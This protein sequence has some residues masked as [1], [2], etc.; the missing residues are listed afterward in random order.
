MSFEDKV[1]I[2]TGAGQGIGEGYARQLA[3]EGASV[4]V[5]ELNESR[6]Q[7]VVDSIGSEGGEALFVKTDVSSQEST[8]S[9]A[10]E[11]KE[12][13]G[14]LHGLVN[15]AAIYAD[16]EQYPLS[17]VPIEYF[18]RF[19]GVNLNGALLCTQA[20]YKLMEQSGGGSIVNQSSAAA[21]MGG[22]YYGIAK[23]GVHA[24]THTFARELGKKKIRVNGI[25]PGTTKTEATDKQ[26]PAHLRNMM[27]MM[28]PLGREAEV[29]EMVSACLFL[30]SDEAS[31]VTGQILNVDGGQVFKP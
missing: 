2:V 17:K 12:K 16:M 1:V 11:V 20:C 6:G 14:A 13:Y 9:M 24:M 21:Y 19:M 31:F 7:A 28:V 18:N 29:S 4:V 26:V 5:A 27:L 8:R 25:A 30:L 15:N 23:L 10:A 22:G 3:R